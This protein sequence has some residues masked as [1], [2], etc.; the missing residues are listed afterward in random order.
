MLFKVEL[1]VQCV[2]MHVCVMVAG[3]LTPAYRVCAVLMCL[4]GLATWLSSH[5]RTAR[6][7]H[8]MVCMYMLVSQGFTQGGFQVAYKQSNG[9]PNS[10]QN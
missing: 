10:S 6:K 8:L 9:P 1:D 4:G 7:Y 5:A 2:F 3:Q